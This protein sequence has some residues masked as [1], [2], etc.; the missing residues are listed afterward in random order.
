MAKRSCESFSSPAKKQRQSTKWATVFQNSLDNQEGVSARAT[1]NHGRVDGALVYVQLNLRYYSSGMA[2]QDGIA[3]YP[4][5]INFLNLELGKF[6]DGAQEFIMFEESGRRLTIQKDKESGIDFKLLQRKKEK[7][8]T[9]EVKVVKRFLNLLPSC[10]YLANIFC[11]AI[12]EKIFEEIIGWVALANLTMEKNWEKFADEFQADEIGLRQKLAEI[13][14]NRY[15]KMSRMV[16]RNCAAFGLSWTFRER[17]NID[18]VCNVLFEKFQKF[19]K[20]DIVKII[21]FVYYKN[22]FIN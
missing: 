17:F 4:A 22:K 10:T 18:G 21:Q 5:E 19:Q 16:D 9:F 3:F 14:E 13:F 1:I 12:P 20:P 7:V 8:C 2:T 11:D 6:L 15:W